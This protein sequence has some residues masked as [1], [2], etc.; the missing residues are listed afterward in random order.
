MNKSSLHEIDCL[1]EEAKEDIVNDIIQLIRIE[2]VKGAPLHGAPFGPG[3]KA[4][5]DAVL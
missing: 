2:S 5:L 1:I 3:P 4:M